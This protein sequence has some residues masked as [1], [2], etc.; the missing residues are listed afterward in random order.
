LI[1]EFALKPGA[2]ILDVGCGTGRHS[3]EL[4]KRGYKVTGIDLS[5]EMLKEALD[6]LACRG[7]LKFKIKALPYFLK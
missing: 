2:A 6:D 3:V 5:A 1:E 4:A 7:I